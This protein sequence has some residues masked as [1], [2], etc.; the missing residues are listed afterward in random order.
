MANTNLYYPPD[1]PQSINA[2]NEFV[3][4]LNVDEDLLILTEVPGITSANFHKI[5]EIAGISSVTRLAEKYMTIGKN[6]NIRGHQLN[7]LFY[8]WLT[9]D[10]KIH[11]HQ[12]EIVQAIEKI[13]DLKYPEFYN[14]T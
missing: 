2:L 13:C 14:V 9:N 7:Q 1:T 5:I 4:L 8:E 11:N 6:L 3:L 12:N 10:V